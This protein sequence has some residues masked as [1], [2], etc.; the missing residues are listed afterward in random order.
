MT[1]AR[2]PAVLA[3]AGSDSGGGAGIQADLRA[4]AAHGVHGTCAITALTAQNTR[5]VTAVHVPPV[6]M[7]H[8]QIDACFEDFDIRAVKI[9]MLATRGVI[10]AVAQALE[11]HRPAHVVLDPVMVATSGATLLEPDAIDALRTRLLPRATL[12]TPN[13]PEAALL[14]G[15]RVETSDDLDAALRALAALGARGVLLKGGHLLD[16]RGVVD[17]L[18]VDGTCTEVVSPRR[19]LEAHGTGCTL[20]SAIAARLARDEALVEAVRG[21]IAFVQAALAAGYVAGRAPLRLLDTSAIDTS[22]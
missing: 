18:E 20:S 9:G 1:D 16:P 13:G 3:I 15:A 12:L 6:D 4:I 10:D 2:R 7:L 11:R 17:T 5:G 21:G 8:T 14:T 22:P 19:A